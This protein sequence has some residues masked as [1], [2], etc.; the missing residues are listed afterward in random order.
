M[1]SNFL[2]MGHID[3]ASDESE[4]DEETQ[5]SHRDFESSFSSDEDEDGPPSV[6]EIPVSPSLIDET[7]VDVAAIRS[8]LGEIKDPIIKAALESM[9]GE[10]GR[11]RQHASDL[12]GTSR[13]HSQDTWPEIDILYDGLIFAGFDPNRLKRN[14]VRRKAEWFKAFYGV[15]HTT[16]APYLAD[17]RKEHPDVDFKDCLMTMN[18]LTGYDVYPVLSAR[19]GYCEEYIGPK[20]WDYCDKMATLARK[21]IFFELAHDIELGRT[22]D[23]ATFMTRE[24]RLTPSSDWFDWKTHSC[25]LK[26]EFCLATREPRITTWISGPHKPSKHDITVF[27][28]GDVDEDKEDWDQ[29]ALYFQLEEGEKCIGDSGYISEPSKV[30]LAKVEHSSNFKKFLDRAKNRQET[31][32]W[33]LKA[34]N[35]LGGRFRHGVNTEER[36][37]LHKMAVEAVAGIIQYDYENGH[38]PFDIC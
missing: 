31:F 38:P 32:H 35:I 16:A 13:C 23:C 27:R 6:V 28:G 8:I 30:V 12:I 15:E 10:P 24:M 4:D 21:K 22:V 34:F 11:A 25:G 9:I 7:A 14:N 29:D 33:R 26:Y 19:W 2:F 18:W 5:L 20:V 1:A 3:A 37:C 36:M 17:L